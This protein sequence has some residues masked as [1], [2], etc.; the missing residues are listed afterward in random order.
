MTVKLTSPHKFSRSVLSLLFL[1]AAALSVMAQEDGGPSPTP[2]SSSSK[3]E[4]EREPINESTD[5]FYASQRPVSCES[6]AALM[7][8]AV[9]KWHEEPG[10]T[11]L[12]IIARPGEGEKTSN[13][14][15]SR[16][17]DVEQYLKRYETIKY[18]T[19]VGSPLKGLGRVELYVGGRLSTVISVRKNSRNVC[20]GQVNP[21]L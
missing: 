3:R 14:S 19:A 21:F 12:I 17:N 1:F 11:Y 15:R 4:Q 6:F 5:S 7:D 8:N 9:I 10:G 16:L 18:V 20:S 13:L 2:P